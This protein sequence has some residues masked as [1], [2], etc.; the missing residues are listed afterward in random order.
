MKIFGL[1]DFGER[2]GSGIPDLFDVCHTELSSKPLFE[3]TYSPARTKLIVDIT[4]YKAVESYE[5]IADTSQYNQ[6]IND[7]DKIKGFINDKLAENKIINDKFSITNDI[8][9]KLVDIFCYLA[10]NGTS[11]ADAIA[12]AIGMSASRTREY[13]QALIAIE[14]VKPDGGNRNRTYQLNER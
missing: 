3:V 1:L 6:N 7:R 13:L 8:V 5:N 11:K 10:D 9:D 12:K 2:A 4:R 14:I